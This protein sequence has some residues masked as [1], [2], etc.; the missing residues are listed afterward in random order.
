MVDP[1]LNEVSSALCWSSLIG[2]N[3]MD[4]V[5]APL[6]WGKQRGKTDTH[7]HTAGWQSTHT[8]GV[9]FWCRH[10]KELICISWSKR[11][12]VIRTCLLLSKDPR[13]YTH[14]ARI[15][16]QDLR[17][18]K[19]GL[20]FFFFCSLRVRCF[21]FPARETSFQSHARAATGGAFHLRYKKWNN[22]SPNRKA[23]TWMRV[24]G[25]WSKSWC[26]FLY[27]YLL[28]FIS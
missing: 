27:Y 15:P 18:S 26:V 8:H 4:N 20:F 17:I 7:T 22:S 16:Q 19:R 2:G 24:W 9:V 5:S 13:H 12:F 3:W 25:D 11:I 21:N 6:E 1:S 23:R 14:R 10:E 28:L